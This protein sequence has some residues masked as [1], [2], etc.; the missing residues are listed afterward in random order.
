MD[1]GVGS[2]VYIVVVKDEDHADMTS[3]TVE[4]T[5]Q[6]SFFKFDSE[7]SEIH[8][9]SSLFYFSIIFIIFFFYD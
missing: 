9:N 1:A 8:F 3:L 2:T 7:R 5:S 4:M 6:N